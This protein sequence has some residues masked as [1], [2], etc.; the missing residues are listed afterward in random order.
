MNHFTSKIPSFPISI[1]MNSNVIM[2]FHCT[3]NATHHAFN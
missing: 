2:E 3:F 1:S